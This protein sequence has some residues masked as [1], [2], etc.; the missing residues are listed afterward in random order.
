MPILVSALLEHRELVANRHRP[1]FTQGRELEV[2][3]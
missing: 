2:K 3:P 1:S